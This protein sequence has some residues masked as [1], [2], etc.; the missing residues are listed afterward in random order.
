MDLD[1]KLIDLEGF[2]HCSGEIKVSMTLP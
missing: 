2:D 1:C